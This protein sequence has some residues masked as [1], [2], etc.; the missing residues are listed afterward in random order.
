[1]SDL[2]LIVTIDTE[3]DD[4]SDYAREADSLENIGRIPNLQHLFE[5][6]GIRPTYLISYPVA[7]DP[8]AASVL[9]DIVERGRCEVG[10]HCHP[11]NTPP[12]EETINKKNSM[13]CNLP[14]ELQFRK[15]QVMH[16]AIRESIGIT[17]VSFRAGRWG[18]GREVGWN[19][20]RLGYRV[21][22]SVT[23]F[24]DWSAHQGPD[25]SAWE[26]FVAPYPIDQNDS[27][28]DNPVLTE[29][30]TTIGFLQGDIR[31]AG[32]VDRALRRSIAGR[33][34]VIGLLDRIGVLN[35]VWLSPEVS[36]SSQMIRL[37]NACRGIGCRYVNMT[38]HSPSLV[39]GL[40]PFVRSC[41][42]EK[43]FLRKIE[44]YLQFVRKERIESIL[45]SEVPEPN[46]P[47]EA[48]EL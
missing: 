44:E 6:Y 13:L 3:E 25:F 4:W 29:M 33:I 36:T 45:L 48:E 46:G 22:S 20:V 21:D 15:L 12:F 2:N 34:G 19:I 14:A 23:P 38:F 32:R 9:R 39:G 11:W 10:T 8:R 5:E 16:D 40:T 43:T 35:K 28:G 26:P 1:M 31:R 7:K 42:E 17:P 24:V 30:P 18:F 27:G 41:S 47:G 37:T